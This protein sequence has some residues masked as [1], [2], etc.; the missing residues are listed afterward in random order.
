MRTP[1]PPVLLRPPPGGAAR[2]R[3][4]LMLVAMVEIVGQPERGHG[5][6]GIDHDAP[7]IPARSP[8]PQFFVSPFSSLLRHGILISRLFEVEAELLPLKPPLEAP[9]A[10]LQLP[11]TPASAPRH[12]PSHPPGH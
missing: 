2:V 8:N 7:P 1:P 9:P 4:M 6:H 12:R 3:I 10:A 5:Q 11:G